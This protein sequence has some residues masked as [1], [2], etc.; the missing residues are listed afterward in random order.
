ML[1]IPRVAPS[2]GMSALRPGD[3]VQLVGQSPATGLA[4]GEYTVADVTADDGELR[5]SFVE[6]LVRP[7]EDAQ[8]SYRARWKPRAIRVRLTLRAKPWHGRTSSVE[9]VFALRC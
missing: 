3:R 4:L 1:L 2:A 7:E 9:S 6:R 5:L 8:V